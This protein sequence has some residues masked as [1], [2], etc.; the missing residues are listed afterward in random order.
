MTYNKAKRLQ[1]GSKIIIKKT[2]ETKTVLLISECRDKAGKK[3]INI[4][5]D[6]HAAHYNF[7]VK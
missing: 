3:C 5:C 6:D 1:N 4:L 2:G 7:E